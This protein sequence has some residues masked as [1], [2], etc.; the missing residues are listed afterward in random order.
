LRILVLTPQIPWPLHQGTA[1]RNFHVVRGL[2]KR[3]DVTLL[4]FGDPDADIEPL[5]RTGM[6]VLTVPPPK[7]RS[8]IRRAVDL[9]TTTTPDLARRLD[10]ETM[11][12]TA[13]L[14]ALMR[15]PFDVIQVEGLEMAAYGF[16]LLRSTPLKF[17]SRLVYDAHN[18]EW[19]LQRRAFANDR[20]RILRWPVAFYSMLQ[21]LKLRRYEGLLVRT[22]WATIAVSD[23]DA[24]ALRSLAPDAKVLVAP[25]GVDTHFFRPMEGYPL[26]PELCVFTGKMDFRPNVDAVQWF[27]DKVWPG[28]IQARPSARFAIV[29]R[30]PVSAVKALASRPGVTVT[31]TVSDV[32]PWIGRAGCFVAPL[33]VGG[34]TRLKILEAMAMGKPIVATSMAVEGLNLST[35]DEIAVCDDP[36][37]M[38][39]C[40]L[41]LADSPDRR[42]ALGE[43]ARRRAE[44]EF[45]WESVGWRIESLYREGHA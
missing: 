16:D 32:R 13:R 19:L 2:A 36:H 28:V 23:A 6:Q 37:E 9:L 8:M 35:P 45:R 39:R 10:S 31:G 34:G 25:N 33:R 4:G 18:A 26:E 3:H 40:I 41:E 43:A 22:A 17:R 44:F 11:K 5:T 7:G 30:D 20:K 12:T 24:E 1:I 27:C 15:E 29:G 42:A 38:T 14:K 21:T